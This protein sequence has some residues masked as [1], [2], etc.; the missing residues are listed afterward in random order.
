[1]D[2]CTEEWDALV[3]EVLATESIAV[4]SDGDECSLRTRP[5]GPITLHGAAAP[6]CLGE[7]R[8]GSAYGPHINPEKFA[9][10]HT[11]RPIG[12]SWPIGSAW[13]AVPSPGMNWAQWC[14]LA[15]RRADEKRA[16][17]E[18]QKLTELTELDAQV[19]HWEDRRAQLERLAS[20][21]HEAYGAVSADVQ[22][23]LQIAAL[24]AIRLRSNRAL[25]QGLSAA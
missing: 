18:Q 25:T 1:M 6:R 13:P 16:A 2:I 19:Q 15:R 24:S 9:P 22:G 7:R 11:Y 21:E 5:G 8:L 23:E 4:T 3:A 12:R 20:L 10:S 14:E 17:R